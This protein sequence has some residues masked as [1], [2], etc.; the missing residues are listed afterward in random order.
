MKYISNTLQ[1][2]SALKYQAENR[3]HFNLISHCSGPGVRLTAMLLGFS[4]EGY[5]KS[6]VFGVGSV[7]RFLK[8]SDVDKTEKEFFPLW[9]TLCCSPQWWVLSRSDNSKVTLC[10]NVAFLN[11]NSLLEN[12]KDSFKILNMKKQ[13]LWILQSVNEIFMVIGKS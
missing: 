8:G 9:I 3:K 6:V 2:T 11:Q 10:F 5:Y 4:R 13:I 1:S 12:S 7:T